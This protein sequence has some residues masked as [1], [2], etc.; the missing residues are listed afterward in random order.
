MCRRIRSRSVYDCR[1][2]HRL[3]FDPAALFQRTGVSTMRRCSR[4]AIS[5]VLRA[6][7]VR[8]CARDGSRARGADKNGGDDQGSGV[9]Y[10]S[11]IVQRMPPTRSC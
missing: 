9:A 8:R 3:T 11:P 4:L 6:D 7:R 5:L 10:W 2:C 1:P